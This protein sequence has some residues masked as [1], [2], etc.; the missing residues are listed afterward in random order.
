MSGPSCRRRSSSTRC[1]TSSPP[2]CR[3]PRII[4]SPWRTIACCWW[5][6]AGS[7]SA[8]SGTPAHRWAKAA[9][10]LRQLNLNRNR[11]LAGSCRRQRAIGSCVPSPLAG[12]GQGGGTHIKAY[13]RTPSPTLPRKRERECTESAARLVRSSPAPLEAGLEA[14]RNL[15]RRRLAHRAGDAERPAEQLLLGAQR[16]QPL[17][18]DA[19]NVGAERHARVGRQ[20]VEA[21]RLAAGP[22]VGLPRRV[23][24]RPRH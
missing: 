9:A 11:L 12:E 1:P 22:A 14:L 2:A 17:V 8:C 20:D 21:Q 15:T 23:R 3:K 10:R 4:V 13:K 5:A 18:V 24:E 16:A 19:G 6:R 7:W